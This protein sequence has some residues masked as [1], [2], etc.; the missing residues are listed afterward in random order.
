MLSTFY[1]IS[2]DMIEYDIWYDILKLIDKEY[3]IE[4]D[5]I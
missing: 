1:G 2:F 3:D 5:S 4:W